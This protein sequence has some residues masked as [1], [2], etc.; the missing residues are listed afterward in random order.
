ME[1]DINFT[2]RSISGSFVS[3]YNT[4]LERLW[5]QDE[6]YKKSE[7]AITKLKLQDKLQKEFVH[8]FA[9]G[10]RNPLQPILG[11]SEILLEK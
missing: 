9:N 8:N 6:L 4:I 2:I 10:L 3:T 1:N 11:F 7:M 5:S